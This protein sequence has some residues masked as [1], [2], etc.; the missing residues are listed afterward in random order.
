[1]WAYRSFAVLGLLHDVSTA[2]IYIAAVSQVVFVV[3]AHFLL[4]VD[5]VHNI[6]VSNAIVL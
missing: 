1:M 6:N 2:V 5:K 4:L 3:V